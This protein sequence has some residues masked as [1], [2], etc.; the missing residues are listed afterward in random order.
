MQPD[1]FDQLDPD[2]A[3][4]LVERIER[5]QIE[6]DKL[7]MGYLAKLFEHTVYVL[8]SGLGLKLKKPQDDSQSEYTNDRGEIDWYGGKGGPPED[9][10]E[11][12][13]ALG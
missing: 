6:R 4:D 9:P 2:E 10:Q 3:E 7:L 8:G 1:V 5:M 13:I 12:V 11:G